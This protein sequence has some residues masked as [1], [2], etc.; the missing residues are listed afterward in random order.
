MAYHVTVT[1]RH[2]WA[3]GPTTTTHRVEADTRPRAI[4]AAKSLVSD[5]QGRHVEFIRLSATRIK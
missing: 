2:P 1:Y 3:F 4:S 5:L